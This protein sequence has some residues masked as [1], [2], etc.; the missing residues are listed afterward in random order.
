MDEGLIPPDILTKGRG[1]VNSAVKLINGYMNYLK[2]A[3][4][5]PSIQEEPAEYF[6]TVNGDEEISDEYLLNGNG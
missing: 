4:K 3:A 5:E 1:L 6:T 2:R